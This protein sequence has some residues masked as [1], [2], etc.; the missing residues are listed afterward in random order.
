MGNEVQTD[1]RSYYDEEARQGLR[2]P[3]KGRRVQTRTEFIALLEAEGRSSVLDFGAGPG[4]DAPAFIDSGHNYVGLDLAHGN[5][6]LA[7]QASIL[8]VHGS[9]AAPPFRAQVFDAGWSMSTLMHVPDQQVEQ[10]LAQ[11]MGPLRDGAPCWVGQW[12]GTLGEHFDTSR[13]PGHRRLFSLRSHER[14]QELLETAAYVERSEVWPT[15]PDGWEYHL[16]HL[17]R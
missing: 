7:A 5:A 8:V 15:G 16:F 13:L 10:V 17:R 11:M 3:L 2:G 6:V 14:N 9:I 1:L 4:R 12:G